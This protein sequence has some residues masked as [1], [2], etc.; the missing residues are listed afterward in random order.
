M[1][2]KVLHSLS[3]L[4]TIRKTV[5]LRS[6]RESNSREPRENTSDVPW[7][8]TVRYA[9]SILTVLEESCPP[10]P[11]Y[12]EVA[13]TTTRKTYRPHARLID[14][15]LPGEAIMPLGAISFNH[16]TPRRPSR[17]RYDQR[18]WQIGS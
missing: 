8:P 16:S 5:S 14:K 15:A 3:D 13:T 18:A 4:T 9:H 6:S 2:I 12:A 11:G 17:V 7:F 1:R 10:L